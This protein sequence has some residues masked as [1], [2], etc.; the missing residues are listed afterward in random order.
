MD[1]KPP[2]AVHPRKMITNMR[3]GAAMSE[4]NALL[5]C[6]FESKIDKTETCWIWTG[7]KQSRG[8]GNFQSKLAH[9]VSYERYVGKIPDGLTLDHLCR[10]RLCVNPAHLEPVS[11][12]K[13]NMRGESPVAK[14]KEKEYCINGHKLSGENIWI[15]K[16]SD[17]TRRKCRLCQKIYRQKKK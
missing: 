3:T 12:Y 17:G 6:T 14:N 16:R 5:P 11:Q 8:Y 1:A 15:I 10:N 13:N 9:R 4:I 2:C 7:A